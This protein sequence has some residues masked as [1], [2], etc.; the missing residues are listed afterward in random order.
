MHLPSDLA[1]FSRRRFL[2]AV[3]AG[4]AGLSLGCTSITD[5][6]RVGAPLPQSEAGRGNDPV[7]M[8]AWLRIAPDG[9]V[10]V[11]LQRAEMGQGVSTV[12]PM[13]V[14]EEL[15]CDWSR[16]E[17]SLD[18]PE[19]V[20]ANVRI[21]LESLPFRED[22]SGFPVEASR[23]IARQAGRLG[24]VITGGSTSV[25]DAWMPL[26]LAG[27]SARMMLLVAA[28]ERL[29]VG[30]DRLRVVRGEILAPDGQRLSFG[31]LAADA[32]RQS[33]PA[34]I[35]LKPRE[36]WT[37]LGRS[38]PKL[39]V[40]AKT[41]GKAIFGADIRLPGQLYAAVRMAPTTGA[42][43]VASELES[44]RARAG[45]AAA[46]EVPS[47]FGSNPGI[48]V[49]SNSHWAA[50]K[51]A[52]TLEARWD[53][54]RTRGFDSAAYQK[55]LSGALDQSGGR[56]WRREGR[57]P[58]VLKRGD[59]RRIE[60]RY[61]TPFLAHAALEPHCCTAL[62]RF[63]AGRA[64]L[65][66]WAPTQLP[67]VTVMVAAEA[68]GLKRDAVRLHPT[69]I[70]GGFGYKGLP[71]PVVQVVTAARAL[72]NRPVQLQWTR[73]QDLTHDT[74]RPAAAARLTAWVD[75]EGRVVGW[76]HS[77]AS[78]SIVQSM[79]RRTLP[80]WAAG[81]VPDKTNVEGAFDKAYDLGA[82]EI[83]HQIVPCP[84][85]VGFWRSV[86]H[87]HHAFFVESFIDEVAAATG[88]DP[89]EFRRRL[90]IGKPRQLRVLNAAADAAGWAHPPGPGKA[91]G[92]AFHESFG[93]ICAQV[94]EIRGLGDGSFQVER[95]V[96]AVDCGTAL[97]PEMIRQQMEG[98]IVFGLT[99][100][101]FGEVRFV[102]G[103][104]Q[105]SNFDT[106]PMLSMAQTPRIET[107][108][109]ESDA[110]LGGIGEVAT[111]PIAP[112]VANALF[113]LTGN[114]ARR[115]PLNASHRF[116]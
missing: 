68:A 25:R 1:A 24:I 75:D 47:I 88:Q 29:K 39:D 113:A 37:L 11:S 49:V 114:R 84:I 4:G 67:T 35:A 85:P 55:Q 32:A 65:E 22:E 109:L 72:P 7:Q 38:V 6:A 9:R 62:Y 2:L 45:I 58:E 17:Y 103:A 102:N 56:I 97:H 70:G 94:A 98:G 3:A 92:I 31:S 95:V 8:N 21:L 30:P 74:W 15:G 83:G 33:I 80:A 28:S 105:L 10:I 54:S 69:L 50:S 40:P 19:P 111:P 101:L 77:S 66:I 100:A 112:A 99:A 73:E 23:W 53:E 36:Q 110:P 57:L 44:V 116:A 52:G 93:S 86:G 51:A 76:R 12:L 106:Y 5:R 71:D 115:L 87:S 14:A 48:V 27:A 64:S 107:M 34:E 79:M 26:R 82:Q 63:E 61:E 18:A 104:A 78:A 60:A 90:L 91:R 42:S 16:V 43:L 20:H 96:C 89:L 81:L 41:S 46:L 59:L 13:L 108:I